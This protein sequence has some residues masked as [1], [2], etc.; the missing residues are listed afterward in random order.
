MKQYTD[1]A[2]A[3]TSFMS[4]EQLAESDWTLPLADQ[5]GFRRAIGRGIRGSRA[6]VAIVQLLE[7]QA[8]PPHS[9]PAEHLL[10]G[11]EGRVTFMIAGQPDIELVPGTLLYIGPEVTYEYRNSGDADAR[12]V[13]V[14]GNV[15]T[16]PGGGQYHN[17]P[18]KPGSES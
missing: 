17:S 7:G 4:A 9:Y 10:F 12:F 2:G 18:T 8:S 14:L 5:P 3:A 13:D 11:L 16:W 6:A 15:S 1:A